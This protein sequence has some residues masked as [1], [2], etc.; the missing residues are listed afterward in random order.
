H[1]VIEGCKKVKAHRKGV[2][3]EATIIAVDRLN[4][5]ALLQVKTPS[6][7]VFPISKEKTPPT[8]AMGNAST[9]LISLPLNFQ[10]L[11]EIGLN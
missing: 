9:E 2:A 6:S 1:H 10:N 4:D 3:Q 11:F 7:Y 5:L 8:K